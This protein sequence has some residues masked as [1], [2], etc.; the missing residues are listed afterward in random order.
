MKKK[1]HFYEYEEKNYIKQK[2]ERKMRKK[3]H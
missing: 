1:I 3:K 2:K